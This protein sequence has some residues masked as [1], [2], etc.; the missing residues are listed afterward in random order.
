MIS[1]TTRTLAAVTVR[2]MSDGLTPVSSDAM[3]FLYAVWSKSA[4]VPATTVANV[5][6]LWYTIPA[7]AGGSGGGGEGTLDAANSSMP[8]VASTTMEMRPRNAKRKAIRPATHM[9]TLCTFPSVMY[10]RNR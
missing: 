6:L 7:G 5:T 4:T 10:L 9:P 3:L 1:D 8:G 2:V